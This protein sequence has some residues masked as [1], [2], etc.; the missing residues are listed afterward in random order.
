MRDLRHLS[1]PRVGC[2]ICNLARQEPYAWAYPLAVLAPDGVK[3]HP[4]PRTRL[5]FDR[6]CPRRTHRA[7]DMGPPPDGP[8][9]QEARVRREVQLEG[10]HGVTKRPLGRGGAHRPCAGGHPS[11][12]RAGEMVLEAGGDWAGGWT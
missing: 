5:D 8:L 2:P 6:G 9:P 10:V 1:D 4:D 11:A 3:D 7:T 12:F